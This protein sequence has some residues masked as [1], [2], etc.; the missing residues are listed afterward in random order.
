MRHEKKGGH[1]DEGL[2]SHVTVV[3]KK[4]GGES[5]KDHISKKR[6][7]KAK[8]KLE[9]CEEVVKKSRSP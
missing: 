1:K 6:E 3:M 4:V 7:N 9:E 8:E 2:V 5:V